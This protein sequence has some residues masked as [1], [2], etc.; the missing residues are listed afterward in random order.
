MSK[1]NE[2]ER[3]LSSIDSSRFHKIV[4]L[5]LNKKYNYEIQNTWTKD[6]E[7][8]P[9]KWTPDTFIL[10]ENWN[11]IFIEYTTQKTN[12]LKKFL[13]DLEKD[14]DEKK[15]K[16]PLSKIEKII[17]WCNSNLKTDEFET[18]KEECLK[19]R[20]ECEIITLSSI[21]NDLFN[22][23]P[24]ILDSELWISIDT[25]Q[26][27]DIDDFIKYNDNNPLSSPLWWDILNRDNTITKIIESINNNDITVIHWDPWVWKTKIVIESLKKI[28][29]KNLIIKTI[30]S[31]NLNIYD[32]LQT[33]FLGNWNYIIFL[34]DAF[35]YKES[36][37]PHLINLI[38]DNNSNRKIKLVFTIR[39]YSLSHIKKI[40]EKFK[41]GFIYIEKLEDKEIAEI[42]EKIYW[43]K[44]HNY[45][46]KIVELAKWNPRIAVLWW[47]VSLNKWFDEIKNPEW[48]YEK[49]FSWVKNDI[50][51]FG[52]KHKK[53]IVI[54]S[55]FHA[56]DKSNIDF[57]NKI[58][59]IFKINEQDFWHI[60]K[61]LYE[62]EILDLYENEIVK[63]S[64][65]IFSSYLFYDIVFKEKIID[66]YFLL[67]NFYVWYSWKIVETLN[68]IL[69]IFYNENI[70]NEIKD[71]LKSFYKKSDE[72]IK[73]KIIYN[74]SR[75][76]ETESILFIKK[77]INSLEPDNNVNFKDFYDI[78]NNFKNNS[79]LELMWN[80]LFSSKY[81]SIIELLLSYIEKVNSVSKDAIMEIKKSFL[82]KKGSNYLIESTFI[83]EIIEKINKWKNELFSRIFIEVWF[84][85]LWT[86]FEINYSDWKKMYFQKI[87]LYFNNTLKEIR[88]NIINHIW[89]LYNYDKY[90][91]RIIEKLIKYKNNSAL[92]Y[93]DSEILKIDLTSFNN[94]ITN[95]NYNNLSECILANELNKKFNNIWWL[96]KKIINNFFSNENYILYNLIMEKYSSKLGI[97]YEDFND[98][99]KQKIIKYIKNYGIKEYLLLFERL[100]KIIDYIKKYEDYESYIFYNSLETIFDYLFEKNKNL[101]LE[102][103]SLYIK[104]WNSLE[105]SYDDYL[106]SK[107]LKII[108]VNKLYKL[109]TNGKYKNKEFFIIYFFKNLPKDK[110]N[111]FY[112]WE[113][114]KFYKENKKIP[115]IS[116]DFLIKYYE[117][118]KNIVVDIINEI[119][120]KAES[121]K[122]SLY[123][124]DYIFNPYSDINKNL[125]FYF[126]NDIDLL[127]KAYITCENNWI[128]IDYKW[129]NFKLISDYDSNFIIEYLDFLILNKDF[130]SIFDSN[131]DFW[132]LWENEEN[133][134]KVIMHI[135]NLNIYDFQKPLLLTKFFWNNYSEKIDKI[136]IFKINFIISFI[137]KNIK[138]EKLIELILLII[139]NFN[140]KD[141]LYF[142]E[143]L[144]EVDSSFDFF[145]K[146][147]L[148]SSISSWSWS[149]VSYYSKKKDYYINL[150]DMIEKKWTK[151]I[152]HLIKIESKID[153]YDK[154]IQEEK[155]KEFIED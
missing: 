125:I 77:H 98:Y 46:E 106:I 144:I 8:K 60:V 108:S 66:F 120:K 3:K 124:L 68:S 91:N 95:F 71:F 104:K 83:S 37:I 57:M 53:V 107:L 143:K 38:S 64:D 126:N 87:P 36:I 22:H 34:D 5:Y 76:L 7:D 122:N 27:L 75:L 151:Y 135:Y 149:K 136:E 59:D 1:I 52:D 139:P 81:K 113:L 93:D 105:I 97:I 130:Y 32:D 25:K 70:I 41:N 73:E 62:F 119:I 148:E 12:V 51:L 26:I 15:T 146:I 101:F 30:L 153:E 152:E 47:I 21:S 103:F 54:V 74:F 13:N 117:Y 155:R 116:L 134:T 44:N 14:I 29:N 127:K 142:I 69:N 35:R 24:W 99:K 111:N 78:D 55:F 132:F 49:Y 140:N 147:E 80:L 133:I 79:I 63:V 72:H 94:F 17:F 138:N 118:E 96:D 45:L 84:L 31:R 145:K 86:E 58:Y 43:I 50:D 19:Y 56:I 9:I 137:Q 23:F 11:Y 28:K 10:L 128:N 18:I 131:I 154:I 61:E 90:K 121:W 4:N 16:I 67:D 89:V 39:E 109:L 48:I 129:D 42:L 40:I 92:Y 115:W 123:S 85:Y 150:K 33:Y 110:I 20:I 6:Y 88:S 141:R 112:L 100:E 2:I 82:Y 65:Q 102:L 114:I